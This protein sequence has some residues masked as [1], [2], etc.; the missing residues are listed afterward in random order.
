MN[1]NIKIISTVLIATFFACCNQSIAASGDLKDAISYTVS[2]DAKTPKLAKVTATFIT[3][4]KF[5]YMFAGANNFPKR[6]AKFVSHLEAKNPTGEPVKITQLEGAK[7]SIDVDEKMPISISYQL[8]LDHEQHK[9]SGGV[10][11]AAYSR[12]SGVFYTGRSIFIVNGENRNNIHIS[13]NLPQKWKVT[14]PWVIDE[15]N[16]KSYKVNSLNELS[17]S[18]FFAGLHKEISIKRNDFELVLTLSS[19]HLISQKEEFKNLAKGVFDYYTDLMGGVPRLPEDNNAKKSLIIISS[20]AATDGEA[21]GNNL[22]ILIEEGGDQMSKVISRFIFAHEFFHLWNGK[23]F[24]PQS[25]ETE[26]F[27]EGFSNYYT[28]K[29]LHHIGFLND[30]SFLSLLANFFYQR[31]EADEGVGNLAMVSGELKHDHWGLIY[32]GGLFV[33]ISQ[34]I[35][36]RHATSNKNSLDNLMRTL[37]KRYGGTEQGYSLNELKTELSILSKS[38]QSEYFDSYIIGTNMLRIGDYLKKAGINATNQN[39]RFALTPMPTITAEQ[40]NIMSGLFGLPIESPD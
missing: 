7:W 1:V 37:F 5:L 40:Q 13:F 28:L 33:A 6:W 4:D 9:W 38:D 23:S 16:S 12:D 22:S 26:W 31:Y 14:T 18:M 21:I 20:G 30:E 25:D 29:S 36:I 34:D 10:D 17:T 15:N 35:M 39:G 19:E 3:Q 24:A 27:K 32:A 11:G 8:N 2:I